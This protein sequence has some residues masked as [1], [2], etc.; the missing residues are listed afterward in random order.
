M[1]KRTQKVRIDQILVDR[2]LAPSRQRAQA[3]VMAGLVLVGEERVEKASQR[4]D[5]QQPGLRVKGSDHPYVSRGGVKLQGALEDF[6][7]DPTDKVCLDVGA[8]TGGFTDCLLQKGARRVYTLDTGTNQLDY[9]IRRDPRV[10]ARENFN[11]RYLKA[12][13]IP[14]PV[15]LVVLDVSFISVKLLVPALLLALSP[16]WTGLF[17]I[18][19]QFEAGRDKVERGGVVTSPEV[20][21]EVLSDIQGFFRAAGLQ[22]LGLKPAVLKGESGNQEFFIF[23]RK[24]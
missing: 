14:E 12:G 20:L 2:G 22:I 9:K 8:S 11:V 15:D 5:P 16:G 21:E 7:I 24:D 4:F 10:V 19:P 23:L 1:S 13:D 18:K 6:A 17:L 3:L